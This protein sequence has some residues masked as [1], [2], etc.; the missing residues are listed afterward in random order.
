M[1][2]CSA[3]LKASSSSTRWLARQRRDPYV[4]Q[5]SRPSSGPTGS[6]TGET[7]RSRSSFKLVSLSRRYPLFPPGRNII[8]LGAAPGGWSQ[9]AKRLL[10]SGGGG[11]GSGG[12]V[13]ALDIL[14]FEP[15]DGVDIIQGDFLSDHVRQE[16]AT[17]VAQGGVGCVLSDM[18][19][20][21]SGVR[22]RDVQASLDL[23]RA[24]TDFA[25]GVLASGNGAD[26]EQG[27]NLV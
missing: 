4:L 23:V 6:H 20:P 3:Q 16:L 25:M 13:I 12:K 15:I 10:R 9:V 11:G 5:R 7:Y 26:V 1:R 24:A 21:M 14:P 2:P 8:D 19:A 27:G 22:M 18:M 17:R